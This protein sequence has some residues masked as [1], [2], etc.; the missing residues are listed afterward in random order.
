MVYR[1]LATIV[2]LVVLI[3]CIA[4]FDSGDQPAASP[5][6]ASADQGIRIN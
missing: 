2:L 5:S 3:A 6:P 1:I 4:L